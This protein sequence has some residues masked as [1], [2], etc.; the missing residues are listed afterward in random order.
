MLFVRLILLVFATTLICDDSFG[1]EPNDRIDQVL[2]VMIKMNDKV[3]ALTGKVNGIEETV[4]MLEEKVDDVTK[5]VGNVTKQIN[6]IDK[7]VDK[8]DSDVISKT[9]LL[10]YKMV[11]VGSTGKR[12]DSVH[13]FGTTM[14]ECLEWCQTKRIIDGGEWNGVVWHVPS[15]TCVCNKN[16]HGHYRRGSDSLHFRAQ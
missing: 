14:K 11:G 4:Q 15:G 5:Q 3:D 13:K 9:W 6:V 7:K 2:A 8:V 10:G 1:G 12:D 16:D